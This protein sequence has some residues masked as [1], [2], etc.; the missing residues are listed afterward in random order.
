MTTIDRRE[1][2]PGCERGW[3]CERHRAGCPVAQQEQAK[4]N[5]TSSPSGIHLPLQAAVLEWS[6][7]LRAPSSSLC[8]ECGLSEM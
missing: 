7:Q 5:T 1:A 3:Y 2:A 8:N 4:A 6:P